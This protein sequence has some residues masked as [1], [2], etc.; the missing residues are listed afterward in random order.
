MT[1]SH[2]SFNAVIMALRELFGYKFRSPRSTVYYNYILYIR[3]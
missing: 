3:E 1:T 2:Y